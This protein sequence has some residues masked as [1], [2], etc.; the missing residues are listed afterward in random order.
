MEEAEIQQAFLEQFET[1]EC[2]V[3]TTSVDRLRWALNFALRDL[4]AL[5]P[6]DWINLRLELAAFTIPHL[7]QAIE[8]EE[9]LRRVFRFLR[10]RGQ[11]PKDG[12][13]KQYRGIREGRTSWQKQ[14]CQVPTEKDVRKL[15]A[16]FRQAVEGLFTKSRVSI[17]SLPVTLT[18]L[19]LDRRERITLL[20]P[21]TERL[22]SRALHTFAH[23]LGTW[24]ALIELC[25]ECNRFFVANRKNQVYC[26]PR[27]QSRV[28]T[29]QYRQHR[30][31]PRKPPRRRGKR[32]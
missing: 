11:V 2:R 28:T 5:T 4:D 15:Q 25:P 21:E 23:L 24:G 3:G 13:K 26:C 9:T 17:G 8:G 31:M 7:T 20:T 29:R 6:G 32:S 18:V 27:C 30:A 14:L 10:E 1:I 19:T 12:R 16:K 22:S